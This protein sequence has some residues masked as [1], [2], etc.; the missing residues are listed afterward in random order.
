MARTR[1]FP[2]IK[3]CR[4]ENPVT[5][6][7][8]ELVAV[9]QKLPA[10]YEKAITGAERVLA[11][12]IKKLDTLNSRFAKTRERLTKAREQQRIKVTATVQARFEKARIAVAELK[13]DSIDLRAEIAM[14]RKGIS[15]LKKRFRQFQTTEKAIEK[16]EKKAAK[17]RKHQRRKKTKA[18]DR[19]TALESQWERFAGSS[20]NK[21]SAFASQEVEAEVE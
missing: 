17:P 16:L 14:L 21:E 19:K 18:S 12:R 13:V 6:L 9:R 7:E 1:K 11:S 8:D 5:M 15:D 3:N 20:S 4:T 2:E 10:E